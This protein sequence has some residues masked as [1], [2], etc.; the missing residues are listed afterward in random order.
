MLETIRAFAA[1]QLGASDEWPLLRDRHLDHF[2]ELAEAA[3]ANLRGS[4]QALWF[5]RLEREY[6]NLRGALEWSCSAH[7][8]SGPATVGLRRASTR[9]EAGVR[10]A[11]ALQF[12]WTV[13]G[14]G[15]ESLPQVTALTA[16]APP[17]TP[18]QADVLTV[19]AYVRGGMLGDF[20]EALAS[21]D[22]ALRLWR[23]MG[24]RDGTIMALLRR[25]QIRFGLGDPPGAEEMFEEARVLAGD[26]AGEIRF[27]TPLALPPARAMSLKGDR[28]RSQALFDEALADARE[29]GDRH[30]IA[31]VL[32][33]LARFGPASTDPECAMS[34]LRE[35]LRLIAPL[36]DV[37]CAM[38]CIAALAVV[39]SDHGPPVVAARLLGA[40]EALRK[41]LGITWTP[42][43]QA[44][45][46]RCLALVQERLATE[47]FAAAYDQGAAMS[48]AQ[49]V[50]YAV[51]TE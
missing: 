32:R 22:E 12:F 3:D 16:L 18:V 14:H 9:V 8:P 41:L 37:N 26:R 28:V 47:A 20:Q 27:E 40:S 46:G 35:S 7:D 39:S 1:D 15:R 19:A 29:R 2:L 25:G 33:D 24:D 43:D 13:R 4:E 5:D 34:L 23:S 6:R 42:H 50:A 51:E 17:G 49:A 45:R 38:L 48:L 11:K 10:L 44:N 31:T 36:D 21:A 30:G